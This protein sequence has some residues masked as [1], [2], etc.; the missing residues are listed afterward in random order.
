M[1]STPSFLDRT[2]RESFLQAVTRHDMFHNARSSNL[3]GDIRQRERG[4]GRVQFAD[5]LSPAYQWES[6]HHRTRDIY[7]RPFLRSHQSA[8]AQKRDEVCGY[9][10]LASLIYVSFACPAISA[11]RQYPTTAASMNSRVLCKL[12]DFFCKLGD[13]RFKLGNFRF[14][15]CVFCFKLPDFYVSWVF[16]TPRIGWNPPIR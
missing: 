8:P 16:R 7:P 15:L 13:D 2:S 11:A 6:K 14:K 5:G 3:S 12:R 1:R 9:V 10:P 4:L